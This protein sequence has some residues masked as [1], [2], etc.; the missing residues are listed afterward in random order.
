MSS[1]MVAGFISST[2]PAATN[3]F[4]CKPASF[5]KS[6]TW[7]PLIGKSLRDKNYNPAER[8]LRILADGRVFQQ[9]Y[10]D[11]FVFENCRPEHV[12]V[13]DMNKRPVWLAAALG[14]GRV[15]YNG[16]ITFAED[17]SEIA[18]SAIGDDERGLIIKALRWASGK[19]GHQAKILN[20][21][22]DEEVQTD[23]IR[24]VISFNLYLNPAAPLENANL[25][26]QCYRANDRRKLQTVANLRLP[27]NLSQEWE[28]EDLCRVSTEPSEKLVMVLTLSDQH[29]Q[30]SWEFPIP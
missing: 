6:A 17:D 5:R 8:Q 12:W 4:R 27:Q 14:N 3:A 10:F 7:A 22:K 21:K 15:V 16:G 13:E 26:A 11:H 18:A 1:I 9:C 30:V 19:S 20:V 28:S 2:I 29:G 23:A 25:A 24:D